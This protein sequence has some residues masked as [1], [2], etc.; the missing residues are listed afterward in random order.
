MPPAR[1]GRRVRSM[2]DSTVTS[3]TA[4]YR[5]TP[6]ERVRV[7]RHTPELLEAEVQYEPGGRLPVAHAH[8]EQVERF[9]VL[10]GRVR[11]TIGGEERILHPGDTATIPKGRTHAM[12]ADGDRPARMIWQTCPALDTAGWWAGLDELVTAYDGEPP[13]PATARLLRR[14]HREFR[15]ALPSPAARLAVELLA[16]LPVRAPQRKAAMTEPAP[17]PVHPS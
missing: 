4:E 16:L 3:P 14:H 6:H 9:A 2:T 12:A 11:M 17:T 15:L 1:R 13:L 10:E 5:L 7:L 8:P